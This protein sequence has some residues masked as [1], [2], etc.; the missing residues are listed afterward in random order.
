MNKLLKVLSHGVAFVTG[1]C[2]AVTALLLLGYLAPRKPQAQ[3]DNY[4]KLEQLEDYLDTYYIEGVDR[5]AL[6][7]AAAEAMVNATGDRWSFYIPADQVAAYK[8]QSANAYVGIGVTVQLSETEK[9]LEIVEVSSGG[10]GEEAGLRVHDLI[11]EAAGQSSYD[12]GL[13]DI[14]NVIKGEEGTSVELLI[15]RDGEEFLLTVER[16]R[17][18]V[19]VA[20]WEML[21]TGYGLVTIANFDSR[22]AQESIAAIEELMDDGAKGIIF[23]L[24]F[25]GGGYHHELVELLDY[26]LPAGP[27]FRSEDYDG[28]TSVDESDAS[29][30]DIPMAVL[31]NGGT[32]SAAEFFAAALQEYDYGIIVGEPTSGKGYFQVNF[33]LNDGSA[34]NISTGR[35]R[36]PNGVSLEGV[37]LTLDV[38]LVLTDEE[39]A[40]LYYGELSPEDDPQ[41]N[42]AI[43]AL[44]SE[45]LP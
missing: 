15:R 6:E 34:V 10:P 5:K 14:T 36:T 38:E 45:I 26:L 43:S 22:C 40:K 3:N 29:C 13:Q 1:I 4:S 23:D 19:P 27:L 41:I 20:T 28:S 37:G 33:Q 11:V 16:R 21:S 44:E 42:A 31:V 2:V 35:Y 9:A 18:E 32:Y 39:M 24:R 8:E 25:N 7:D 12:L 30:V 17:V